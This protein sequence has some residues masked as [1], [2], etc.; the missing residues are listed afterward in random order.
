MKYMLLN[1]D[2]HIV[3]AVARKL[4]LYY[5]VVCCLL[6]INSWNLGLIRTPCIKHR[7]KEVIE[8]RKIPSV[9]VISCNLVSHIVPPI[10]FLFI[11]S[12]SDTN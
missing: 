1:I 7:I 11:M 9:P 10:S 8:Y 3:L 4:S 12:S 2:L 6:E 5:E